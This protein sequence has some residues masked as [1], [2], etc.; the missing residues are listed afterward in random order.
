MPEL[1]GIT[2]D[3]KEDIEP[4]VSLYSKEGYGGDIAKMDIGAYGIW[5][6]EKT[7]KGL[8]GDCTLHR[9]GKRLNYVVDIRENETFVYEEEL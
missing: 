3:E 6:W 1:F 9:G 4:D 8:V 7:D 5:E 2:F